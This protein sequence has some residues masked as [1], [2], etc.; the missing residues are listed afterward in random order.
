MGRRGRW[1]EAEG[2]ET[3]K[4]GGEGGKIEAGREEHIH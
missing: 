2:R 3:G 1:K 4:E